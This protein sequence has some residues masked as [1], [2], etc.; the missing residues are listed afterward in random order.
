MTDIN[1]T[2]IAIEAIAA[3]ILE[4]HRKYA[5]KDMDWHKIAAAKVYEE[6]RVASGTLTV[7]QAMQCVKK[8]DAE[9]DTLGHQSW[10]S[11]R[12]ALTAKAR[13]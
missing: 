1:A 9:H 13:G 7:D 5:H 6:L 10:D 11:L 12:E 4:E 3:R 8:W 2:A